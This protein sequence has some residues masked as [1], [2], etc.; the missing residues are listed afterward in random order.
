MLYLKQ[1]LLALP[2][3]KD[4]QAMLSPTIIQ[5]LKDNPPKDLA[6]KAAATIGRGL[7]PAKD[8]ADACGVTVQAINGWKSNGRIGKQHIKTL[9]RLTGLPVSWWLPGDDETDEDV[10]G[11]PMDWPF[12]NIS[13]SLIR[14]LPQSTLSHLEGV[15]L[16][17][18]G[19]LGSQQTGA[20]IRLPR[21]VAKPA[22][23]SN[24]NDAQDEFPM[25]SGDPLP[26]WK[27]G[28][29]T[30]KRMEQD[31]SVRF[32]SNDEVMVNVTVG[33]P[34]PTNDRFE[35]VPKLAD[36]RLAAGEGIE[37]HSEAQTGVI[38]FRQS[39]LRSIG[40]DVPGTCVVYAEGNSMEPVIRNGAELLLVP[41]NN[42]A[43]RELVSGAVYAINYEGKMIVKSVVRDPMKRRWVARSFNR[44]YRDIDLESAES[45]RILGRVV[46]VGARLDVQKD[47]F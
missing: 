3:A 42:M 18:L 10:S 13:P 24:L 41:V 32:A 12:Q 47:F 20:E 26:P 19:T 25:R 16:F 43:L 5:S 37:V 4:N 34:F 31:T 21:P 14:E 11:A 2:C 23:A 40:A 22:L 1:P 7:V 29:P 9:A 27:A 35:K 30:T 38:Q 45:V 6:A 15:L 8:V 28:S 36:V 44:S 17:A 33:E 46:W 39:F